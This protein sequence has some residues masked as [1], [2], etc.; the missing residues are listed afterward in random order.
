MKNT[1]KVLWGLVLVVV[2]LLLSINALGFAH[3]D[4][5]FDG[6]WTLF[7]IVPSFIGLFGDEDKFGSLVGLIVGIA[8]LLSAQGFISFGLIFKLI[9]PFII[10]VIG[11]SI[12]K[13]GI[14]GE[15]VKEK[16]EIKNIKDLETIAVVMS[17]ENKVIKDEFKGAVIDTVF[18]HCTLDISEA[19]IKGDINIK[20][21]SVFSKVDIIM[22]ADVVIKTNSTRVFGSVSTVVKDKTNKKGTTIYVEAVSVFGGISLR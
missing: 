5:F 7:I 1:S 21:S 19:K 8:L 20:I 6:W 17:D 9:I 4:I 16:V 12:L 10:V 13:N 11:L 3:I 18:G 15:K 22:P 2:G 14:Y